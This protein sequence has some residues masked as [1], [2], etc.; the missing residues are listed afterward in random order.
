MLINGGNFHHIPETKLI[1]LLP[2]VPIFKVCMEKAWRGFAAEVRIHHRADSVNY[3]RMI[4]FNVS[5]GL[6]S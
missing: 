1:I 5:G 2:K 4:R 6:T 3:L